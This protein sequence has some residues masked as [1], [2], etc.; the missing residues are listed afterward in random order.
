MAP[1]KKS[2]SETLSIARQTL[3]AEAAAI[4]ALADNLDESFARAVEILVSCQGHVI[5]SGVGTTGMIARRLAHLLSNVGCPALFLHAGD[6]LHG[7]SGAIR[8]QDVVVLLSKSGETTE[9]TQ[10]AQILNERHTPI[11][12]LTARPVST[13]GKLSTLVIRIETPDEID[14]FDGLMGVGSSLAAGAV[15]DALVFAVWRA[16]GASDEAFRAGHPGGVIAYL[17]RE[18]KD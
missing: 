18:E 17:K 10:L 1:D 7:S 9:T 8:S 2:A 15:C 14:P 13:L 3:L 12:A 16:K 6:S 5:A 4:Q 11:I